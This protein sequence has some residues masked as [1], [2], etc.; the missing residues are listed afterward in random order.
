M[1]RT[2]LDSATKEALPGLNKKTVEQTPVYEL[3]KAGTSFE[4]SLATLVR[5]AAKG[6][7][8]PEETETFLSRS[9]VSLEGADRWLLLCTP[10]RSSVCLE[11]SV[12]FQVLPDP[13]I[14]R[15]D[16]AARARTRGQRDGSSAIRQH[17]VQGA[18]SRTLAGGT[19][20]AARCLAADGHSPS[21]LARYGAYAGAAQ[22]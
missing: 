14:R 4:K 10:Q 19:G 3:Y 1:R 17:G 12:P 11:R 16:A 20:R 6:V 22:Q 5:E 18:P 15:V 7:A 8:R 13:T 21:V 9:P 2:V